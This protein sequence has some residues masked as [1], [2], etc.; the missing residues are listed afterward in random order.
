MIKAHFN[1]QKR[2]NAVTFQKMQQGQINVFRL[3][4]IFACQIVIYS[5]FTNAAHAAIYLMY[6]LFEPTAYS[7][8]QK[9]NLINLSTTVEFICRRI[10]FWIL[11]GMKLY[12]SIIIKTKSHLSND[13]FALTQSDMS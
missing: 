12:L 6:F 3:F 9:L 4:R 2:F 11:F 7:V 10:I 1:C 8:R 5:Y 13:S